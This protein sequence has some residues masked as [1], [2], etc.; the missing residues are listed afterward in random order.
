MDRPYSVL[1]KGDRNRLYDTVT[2]D[3]MLAHYADVY[4][5]RFGWGG[6]DGMP[7]DFP[8]RMLYWHGM[9]G[10]AEAFG[11]TVICGANSGVRGIFGQPLDYFPLAYD[12]AVIP[13]GWGQAHSGPTCWLRQV[14]A[15]E[16]SA[17]CETSA[18][19]WRMLRQNVRGM[20]QPVVMQGVAGAE[21][22]VEEVD[23]AISGYEL[24]IPTLKRS[25][26]EAKALKLGTDDHVE[27]FIKVFNA[28]DCEIL[29]RFGI[30]SA[31]TEKA[32][33]VTTV[34]TL[35]ITQELSLR[36]QNELKLRRD[37]CESVSDVLPDLYVEPAP[38]LFATGEDDTDE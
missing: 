6:V 22:N 16:I 26:V 17:L 1:S 30:K 36:L 34:E 9:I 14:P 15:V 11:R 35:S 37:F 24:K 18:L 27:S 29:A 4:A 19:A 13:E 20:A 32:S 2:P 25:A 31:G 21:L 7:S 10:T 33:G 8:E 3:D 23:D 12:S 38:G 5:S 28:I